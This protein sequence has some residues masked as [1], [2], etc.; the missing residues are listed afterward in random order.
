MESLHEGHT[1]DDTGLSLHDPLCIWYLLTLSHPTFFMTLSKPQDLRVE[2]SGQWTRGMYVLDRRDRFKK[3]LAEGEMEGEEPVEVVGDAGR[4][5]D[6]SI[7]NQIL[8]AVGSGGRDV[9]GREM[10]GRILEV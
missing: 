6:G 1:G 4:W 8:V 9:M 2:T 5:L 3:G 7:G 10:L